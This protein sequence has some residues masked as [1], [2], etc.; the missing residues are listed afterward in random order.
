[1]EIHDIDNKLQYQT[2]VDASEV[3]RVSHKAEFLCH[4]KI[5]RNTV[6]KSIISAQFVLV[7]S[8]FNTLLSLEIGRTIQSNFNPLYMY[9]FRWFGTRNIQAIFINVQL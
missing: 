6:G 2:I 3:T 8:Y 1:M 9:Y 7:T 4:K 5:Y